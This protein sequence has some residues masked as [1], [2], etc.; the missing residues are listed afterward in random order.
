MPKMPSLP[1]STEITEKVTDAAND[2]AATVE[3]RV[4]RVCKGFTWP[5]PITGKCP[6]AAQKD[7]DKPIEKGTPSNTDKPIETIKRGGKRRR[8]KKRRKTRRKPR[9]R[10]KTRRRRRRRKRRTRKR[11]KTRRKTRRG[12]GGGRMWKI[13]NRVEARRSME[14]AWEIGTVMSDD[15]THNN[16]KFADGTVYTIAN[17]NIRP[18]PPPPP[19]PKLRRNRRRHHY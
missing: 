9:R 7:T 18:P 10:R 11:R 4:G 3:A 2:A 12:G 8:R 13:G 6:V 19:R 1:S 15:I 17:S 5:D 14:G 16:I